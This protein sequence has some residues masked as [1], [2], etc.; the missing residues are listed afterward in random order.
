MIRGGDTKLVTLVVI[1][2][3]IIIEQSVKVGSLSGCQYYVSADSQFAAYQQLLKVGT[4]FYIYRAV[5]AD[6]TLHVL[7]TSLITK[8]TQSKQEE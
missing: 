3:T 6:L 2:Q 1:S 8:L 4:M 5:F 7:F